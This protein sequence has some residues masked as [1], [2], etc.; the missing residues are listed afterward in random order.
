MVKKN[1]QFDV[2]VYP[3]LDALN[4]PDKALLE[5]ARTATSQSYAPYSHFNVAAV[6]MLSNGETVMGTNQENAS[7]PVGICAERAL[8]ASAA[9]LYPGIAID[10]M[11]IS[12]NNLNAKSNRPI[13]PCGMCRQSLT[14]YEERTKQPIRLILSGMEGEVYIIEKAHYILPLTFTSSDLF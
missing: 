1:I 12:Y 8:L 9:S 4:N 14:E 3:S 6:A 5:K 2:E 11:A 7:F 13:S 10:T